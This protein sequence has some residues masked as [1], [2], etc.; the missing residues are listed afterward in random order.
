ML[1]SAKK[2]N[3]RAIA[4]VMAL[5]LFVAAIPSSAAAAP[6]VDSIV[7]WD[8]GSVFYADKGR[9][10]IR[11]ETD[12]FIIAEDADYY[13][14]HSGYVDVF[15]NS[16]SEIPI[17]S[18]FG[19]PFTLDAWVTTIAAN[20]ER[21][22]R[23]AVTSENNWKIPIPKLSAGEFYDLRIVAVKDGAR[24]VVYGHRFIGAGCVF[25]SSMGDNGNVA[26]SVKNY[27][28]TA[29]NGKFIVGVYKD[30]KLIHVEIGD[31]FTVASMKTHSQALT[32][33]G[34]PV[35]EYEFIAF[36]W[37][38]DFVPLAPKIEL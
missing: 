27:T 4:A 2:Y 33:S 32:A 12:V 26:C 13:V 35:G 24:D 14:L 10:F 36:C 37:N 15:Y 5:T 8:G 31:D 1:K 16:E 34:Y 22:H 23:T 21:A 3:C 38:T 11:G 28:D 9:T 30:A 6:A 18:N 7:V 19:P 20:T 17:G 25:I 29:V